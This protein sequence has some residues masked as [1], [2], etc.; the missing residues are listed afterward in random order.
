MWTKSAFYAPFIKLHDG[1][2]T[3]AVKQLR[4]DA[5]AAI[6]TVVIPAYKRFQKFFNEEYLP[7]TR[8]ALAVT[9]IPD[10]KAYYAYLVRHFTTTNL[11]PEQVHELGLKKMA[12]IHEQMLA[13][14]KRTGFHG[15]FQ[16]FLHALRTD[17]KFYYKNAD[18]LLVAYKAEAKTIDPLLVKEFG[19]LPRIPWGISV[20][21][22][23]QAPNTY[24]AYSNQPSADG[25]RPAFMAVNLYKPETRPKYEI[26]VLTCHEG[27][28]GHALQLAGHGDDRSAKVPALWLLQRLWGG[29]GVVFRSVMQGDGVI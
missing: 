23:D 24:P 6:T 27:R 2:D 19:H 29:V 22:M 10:G 9:T 21:P 25:S 16:E 3:T 13:V 14:I 7:R 8:T 15:T 17:P 20:I 12:E 26:P 4:A 1:I 28:P 11:T 5:T 18:D